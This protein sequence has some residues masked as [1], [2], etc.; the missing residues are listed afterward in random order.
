MIYTSTITKKGQ[1][2]IPKKIREGLDLKEGEKVFIELEKDSEEI[3]IKSSPD[4][5]ELAGKF[6]PKKVKDAV[7]LREKMMKMYGS[8]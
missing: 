3:K 4:I 1:I 8:R 2:T 6:K 5:F 7:V